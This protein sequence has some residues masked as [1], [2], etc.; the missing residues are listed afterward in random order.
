[1]GESERLQMVAE[2]ELEGTAYGSVVLVLKRPVPAAE[3]EGDC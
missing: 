3:G 2:S 1:M